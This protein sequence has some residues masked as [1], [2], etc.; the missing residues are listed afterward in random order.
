MLCHFTTLAIEDSPATDFAEVKTLCHII[1]YGD[2]GWRSKDFHTAV[3]QFDRALKHATE[4][5]VPRLML[6]RALALKNRGDTANALE[7]LEDVMTSAPKSSLSYLSAAHIY[8][9]RTDPRNAVAILDK[10]TKAVPSNDELY[11][12]IATQKQ[13]LEK[14]LHEKNMRMMNLFSYEIFDAIFGQLDIRD[15]IQ[16]AQVCRGWQKRLMEWPGMWSIV[17]MKLQPGRRAKHDYGSLIS[18]L[19]EFKKS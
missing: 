10:A 3:D 16:C 5:L 11:A 17:D 9:G 19:K 1:Q 7:G 6:K 4:V 12:H 2:D 8:Q 15:R 14:T 18:T 13:H